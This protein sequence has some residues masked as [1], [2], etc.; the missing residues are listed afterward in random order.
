MSQESLESLLVDLDRVLVKVRRFLGKDRR[1]R[2]PL[3]DVILEALR[4]TNGLTTHA[5]R[6]LV[7]RDRQTVFAVL[8]LLQDAGRVV[9]EPNEPGGVWR[10]RE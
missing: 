8:R 2:R 9:R 3:D 4:D 6:R 5:L 1:D 7:Q 10:I